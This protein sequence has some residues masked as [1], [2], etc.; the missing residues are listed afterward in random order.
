VIGRGRPTNKPVILFSRVAID[1]RADSTAFLLGI[2]QHLFVLV[3]VGTIFLEPEERL[4]KILSSFA[5]ALL[6]AIGMSGQASAALIAGWTFESSIPATAGSHV[7]ELGLQAGTAPASGFHATG[8][9][10]YSNPVGNGSN[11]SFSSNNWTTIGD[12]YQFQVNLAGYNS[13]TITWDQTRSSTGPSA[14]DLQYS[15]DGSTFNTIGSYTVLNNAAAAGPPVVPGAWNSTTNYPVYTFGPTSLTAAVDNQATVYVRLRS[16]ATAASG[17]TNR[18]DNVLINAQ[19][20]P[21]PSAFALLGLS[22][23]RITFVRRRK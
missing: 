7:A 12:Y 4:M 5:I 14:F 11:E 21:E 9:T 20:I 6:M 2:Y 19:Q 23:A 10:T 22:V 8:T 1:W 16:R 18:V 13:A 15:I 17:G 3:V